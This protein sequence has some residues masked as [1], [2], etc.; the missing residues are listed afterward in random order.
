MYDAITPSIATTHGADE[1]KAW[2]DAA[3]CRDIT[4]T[5]WGATSAVAIRA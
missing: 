4:P 5:P 2:F 1:L 3:G